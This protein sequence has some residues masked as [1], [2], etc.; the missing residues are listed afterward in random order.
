MPTGQPRRQP[1]VVIVGSGFA[2]IGA[3][4]ALRA[5]GLTDITILEKAAE[6]GGVWRDNTYPGAACDIPSAL[7]SYSF[8]PNQRWSR[9]F[10]PA[11]E[12]QAYLK[13]T[14]AEHDV[15]RSI[16]FRTEVTAADF[17]AERGT[18][19]ITMADGERME[20]EV[21]IWAVGQLSRPRVPDIAGAR[22]FAGTAFHSARWDHQCD[23][24]GKSVA[25]IGTG[26]STAQIVPAIAPRAAR[27]TVFQRSAP[28]VLPK[29]DGFYGR[30]PVPLHRAG[31]LAERF[32]FW[33]LFE[34]FTAAMVTRLWPLRTMMTFI[35]LGYM[36]HQVRD[37]RL[38]AALT[39]GYPMGCKRVLL[40]NDY[41]AALTRPHVSVVTEPVTEITPGGVRARNGVE[42]PADVIVYG[43]GFTVTGFLAPVKITGRDGARLDDAWA[44]GARAYYGMA[45]PGFPNMFLMYG[46]GT[47]LAAGS[48]IYMLERQASYIAQAVRLLADTVPSTIDVRPDVA[49]AYDERSRVRLAATVWAG[50]RSWYTDAAGRVTANWP[51][52]TAE[53]AWRTR[54]L[55]AADFVIA[56]AAATPRGKRRLTWTPTHLARSSSPEWE[57]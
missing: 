38:R 12:I 37:P 28:Y 24:T 10:A 49:D 40:S 8:A 26:A 15:Y 19:L 36:R 43:T 41:L 6:A 44:S 13:R 14:A 57:P 32:G 34:L 29:P 50:C 20:A 2:G 30:C 39:P 9:R 25:V 56:P 42:Y 1:S 55:D 7:Y 35:A 17:A 18:W 31:Q 47:N 11:G 16:R 22:Q 3:A 33:L 5:A 27:L 45:V 54:T 48:I 52:L 46:P 4:I 21:L 51:G 53:Y 23:L